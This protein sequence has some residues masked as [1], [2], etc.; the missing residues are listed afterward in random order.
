MKPRTEMEA[1]TFGQCICDPVVTYLDVVAAIDRDF[2]R[3]VWRNHLVVSNDDIAISCMLRP[4]GDPVIANIAD[5]IVLDDRPRNAAMQ[6][7]AVGRLIGNPHVAD[8]EIV[9]GTVQPDADFGMVEIQPIESGIAE[10]S[11]DRGKRQMVAA[12]GYV[13]LDGEPLQ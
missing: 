12:L 5:P 8:P 4:G 11:S 7:D 6:V 1:S 9:R 3:Q 13:T 10:R 2:V